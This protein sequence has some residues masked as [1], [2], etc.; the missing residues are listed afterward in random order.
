VNC[1]CEK[2]DGSTFFCE[3]H[4]RVKTRLL[5]EKCLEGGKWWE[6]WEEGRGPMLNKNAIKHEPNTKSIKFNRRVRKGVG[7]QLTK[8]FKTASL[9]MISPCEGCR[10]LATEMNRKGIDW[11]ESNMEYILNGIR[12]NAKKMKVPFNEPFVK[13]L[14]QWAIRRARRQEVK[15]NK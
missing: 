5:R 9:G 7:T 4:Q 10:G 15:E 12:D 11:C 8:I 1:Y 2:P 6:A 3:R 13:K 14:V